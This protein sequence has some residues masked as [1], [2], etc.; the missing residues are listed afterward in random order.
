MADNLTMLNDLINPE[1]MGDMISAKLEAALSVLPYATVDTRLQG[2]A[3]D[4]ITIPKYEYIGDAVDVPEGE[5]IPTRTLQATSVK[6]TIKKVGIGCTLTDEAVLCGYG[7]PVGEANSQ[8]ALSIKS[9][10][11]RDMIAALYDAKTSFLASTSINY[12]AIVDG[13]DLFQDENETEKVMWVHPK[14]VTQ[15]RKDPDFISKEKYGNEVMV[16]GEIGMIAGC[17]VI[18][19]RRVQQ[20]TE[21]YTL[22]SSGALEVVASGGDD[23]TKVNLDKVAPSLPSVKVGDKVTKHDEKVYFNPIV[24]TKGDNETEDETAALTVF[25][26]RNINIEKER[27][28]KSRKTEI[29]GDE[30]YAA[31]LTNESKVVLLKT[32]V[33]TTPRV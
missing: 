18:A 6:H 32:L 25:I 1:V 16:T 11:D 8:M 9:K 21:W 31:A 27:I 20:F 3:G 14:Q 19:S 4:T 10:C 26:K 29:T 17:R 7:N 12:N 22:D 30:L 33:D 28:S 2:Q 24:K 13:V 5:D 23:S 15:L